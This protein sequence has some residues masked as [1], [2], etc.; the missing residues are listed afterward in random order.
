MSHP[1][2]AVVSLVGRIVVLFALLMLLPLAFAW[3]GGH[4]AAQHAFFV[5]T[6]TTFGVG[7]LV[8]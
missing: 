3:F 8:R 4:D 6:L 5:S 1:L 7:L 2:L